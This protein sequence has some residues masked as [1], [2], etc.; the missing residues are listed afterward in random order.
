MA[1]EHGDTWLRDFGN[2]PSTDHLYDEWLL[3]VVTGAA[4]LDRWA[5]DCPDTFL[6]GA[7]VSNDQESQRTRVF[8][9]AQRAKAFKMTADATAMQSC[10]PSITE[11]FEQPNLD[12]GP[13]L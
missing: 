6:N 8:R 1:I 4:Y 12:S 13:D 11:L 7:I 5:I 3:E 10:A 2:P 9:A